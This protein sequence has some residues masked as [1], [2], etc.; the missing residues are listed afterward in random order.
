[1]FEAELN[2]CD[3]YK[4]NLISSFKSSWNFVEAV[5]TVEKMP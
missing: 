5:S 4:K 3:A 2:F 1:M